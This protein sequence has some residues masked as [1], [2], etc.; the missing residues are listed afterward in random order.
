MFF[1]LINVIDLNKIINTCYGFVH[2]MYRT[3]CMIVLSVMDLMHKR[4]R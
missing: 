4:V 1:I 2:V 3:V